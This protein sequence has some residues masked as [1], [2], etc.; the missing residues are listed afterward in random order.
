MT[1]LPLVTETP[2]QS[3]VTT[4]RTLLVIPEQTGKRIRSF[5]DFYPYY[6]S[7]HQHV[8]CRR[9][10]FVGSSLGLVALASALR[11]RQ[12]RHVFY[13]LLAGYG[14]AWIG[15][16]GYEKNRPA[17]FSQP[18]FSLMADWCMYADIWRGRVSLFK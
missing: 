4:G 15:H 14:C 6:L 1:E 10:H 5:Q 2:Q 3:A 17:T 8:V 18:V 7:E 16:F 11:H 9:W 13:G 12:P